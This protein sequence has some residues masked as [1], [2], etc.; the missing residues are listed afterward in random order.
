VLP[1]VC[2]QLSTHFTVSCYLGKVCQRFKKVSPLELEANAHLDTE[3]G[4][5]IKY[6]AASQDQQFMLGQILPTDNGVVW[7]L[8]AEK[9]PE[10]EKG[11]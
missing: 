5:I 9:Q 4:K 7:Q 2:Q 11:D 1:A 6:I 3:G 10:E 8:F